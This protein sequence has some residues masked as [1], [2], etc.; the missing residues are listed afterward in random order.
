MTDEL[1]SLFTMLI[2]FWNLQ[3]SC[4]IEFAENV[5]KLTSVSFKM[6]RTNIFADIS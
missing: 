6:L 3:Y 2:F 1:L 4:W 5:L